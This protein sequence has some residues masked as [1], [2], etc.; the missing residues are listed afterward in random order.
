MTGN[1]QLSHF[2]VR[3][4]SRVPTEWHAP[5]AFCA[6][7]L[8]CDSGLVNPL[9]KM[10]D[11]PGVLIAVSIKPLQ[12]RDYQLWVDSAVVRTPAV[13][14][15][16]SNVIDLDAKP[17]CWAGSSF[18]YL[19]YHIPRKALDDIAADLGAGAVGNCRQAVVEDDLVIAQ[20]TKNI[21]P[22][23][24]N[25]E[26]QSALTLDYLQLILGAHLLQHYA[27]LRRR[28]AIR[29]RGLGPREQRRAIELLNEHLSGRITLARLAGECGQSP[30]HF[31]RSFKVTFGVS[32]LQWLA[33]RRIERSKQ[34]LL[35]SEDSLS[36]IAYQLGFA[37]QAAFTRAFQ[38]LAGTSPGRWRRENTSFD[39]G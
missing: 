10:A 35:E 13:A 26:W 6:V 20:I 23:L 36:G 37:D 7:R 31:A 18:D 27:G 5:K 38:R 24:D 16:R 15:L 14:P 32:A 3:D 19:N 12:R 39:A 1:G 28:P 22:N 29:G 30:S 2:R 21:L 34:L 25:P 9:T 33:R 4:A 17:T 8:E 11:A